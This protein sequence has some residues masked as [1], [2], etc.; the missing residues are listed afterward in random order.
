MRS[1]GKM[2]GLGMIAAGAIL[3]IAGGAWLIS[4]MNEDKLEQ[5]GAI[6]G[7]IL[8]LG[9]VVIP[10]VGGGVFFTRKGAMEEQQLAKINEQRRLLDI[11]STRGQVSIADLVLELKSSRDEVEK[12]LNE[13]VGRGLFSGY[14]DWNKGMLYSVDASKLQ[15]AQFCPNCGGKLELAGKGVVTCPYCGAQIFLS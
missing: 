3:G 15:G 9:V 6:F 10:L 5:S 2:I 7:L 8:L 4:G 12:N 14:V 1:S 13:L 11:V